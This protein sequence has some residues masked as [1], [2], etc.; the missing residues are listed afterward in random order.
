MRNVAHRK[1]RL[2][3][4]PL[5]Q[6]DVSFAAHELVQHRAHLCRHLFLLHA[7]KK[8]RGGAFLL[9]IR[10][11]SKALKEGT[12][13]DDDGKNSPFSSSFHFLFLVFQ[14]TSFEGV[15]ISPFRDRR[16]NTSKRPLCLYLYLS[17]YLSIYLS[18]LPSLSLPLER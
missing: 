5:L 6:R 17:I 7:Q 4:L 8:G 11:E 15:Q 9:V 12:F 13:S 2:P 1:Q 16:Y 3:V 18:L 10:G 14:S